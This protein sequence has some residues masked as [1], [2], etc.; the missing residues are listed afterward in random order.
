MSDGV[1]IVLT[2]AGILAVFALIGTCLDWLQGMSHDKK[3]RWMSRLVED[4][5]P[6]VRTTDEGLSAVALVL[7]VAMILDFRPGE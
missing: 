7:L 6:K 1:F 5:F 4:I 3:E 2:L